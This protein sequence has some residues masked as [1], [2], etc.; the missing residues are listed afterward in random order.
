[1]ANSLQTDNQPSCPDES[2]SRLL[3]SLDRLAEV[4]RTFGDILPVETWNRAFCGEIDMRIARDGTWFYQGSPIKR[5][6]LVRLFSRLLRNDG[7]RY[8]LVT[9]VECVGIQVE[10]VPFIA[11]ELMTEKNATGQTLTFRTNLGDTVS[12]NRDHPLRFESGNADGLVPY[13]RVRD[14]LWARLTPSLTIMEHGSTQDSDGKAMFGIASAD[15]F[16][17]IAATDELE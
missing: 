1:M 6:A 8:V 17:P 10:D 3:G 5:P 11:A 12:A 4:S 7:E 2:D 9:P 14:G 13:V 16:F 15:A